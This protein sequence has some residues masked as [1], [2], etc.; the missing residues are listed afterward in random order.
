[1][2]KIISV[3]RVNTRSTKEQKTKEK[4]PEET[5]VPVKENSLETPD[6]SIDGAEQKTTESTPMPN[7]EEQGTKTVNGDEITN[8]TRNDKGRFTN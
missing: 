1:M 8:N 3:N 4:V 7:V 2:R 6:H 5:D